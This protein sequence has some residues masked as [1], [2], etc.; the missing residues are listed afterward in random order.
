MLTSLP[1][2]LILI[3]D[4]HYFP[5]LYVVLPSQLKSSR[6]I[7]LFLVFLWQEVKN[8]NPTNMLI[9]LIKCY[10]KIRKILLILCDRAERPTEGHKYH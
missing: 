5:V 1:L 3:S 4:F 10:T 9:N 8:Y 7:V 2:I 6:F